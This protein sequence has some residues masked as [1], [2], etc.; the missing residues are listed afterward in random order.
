MPKGKPTAQTLATIKYEKKVGIKTKGFKLHQELID[1]YEQACKMVGVNQT[2]KIKELMQDFI[3][4]VN[5]E[6]SE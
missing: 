4:Q 1:Q 3:D 2:A 5:K 6:Y